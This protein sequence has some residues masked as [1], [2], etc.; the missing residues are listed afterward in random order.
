MFGWHIETRNWHL[1]DWYQRPFLNQGKAKDVLSCPKKWKSCEM[2]TNMTRPNMIH[3]NMTHPN[4]IQFTFNLIRWGTKSAWK[5][6]RKLFES[7]F[8]VLL[9]AL[10][11]SRDLMSGKARQGNAVKGWQIFHIVEWRL[12]TCQETRSSR[13]N[14]ALR[15]DEAVYWVSVGQQCNAMVAT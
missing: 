12:E 8:E 14:C 4:M 15:G 2:E 6:F 3:P 11:E 5:V 1:N 10:N 13:L 7:K 9:E